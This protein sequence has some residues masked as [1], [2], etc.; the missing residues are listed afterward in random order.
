MTLSETVGKGDFAAAGEERLVSREGWVQIVLLG[1][2][3]F[4]LFY[5]G[6]IRLC[7]Q[8][9]DDPDWQHALI[10]PLISLYFIYQNR[11]RL[12]G[13]ERRHCWV[14]LVMI[15]V[16]I[17]GYTLC[18]YPYRF[19]MGK[20]YM[21]IFALG[22]LVLWMTGK[23]MSKILWFPV[24]YLSFGV[25]VSPKLWGMVSSELQLIASKGASILIDI[26][27]IPLGLETNLSGNQIALYQHAKWIGNLNVAEACSGI[28]SLMMFVALGVAVAFL[29]Q[30]PWWVKVIMVVSTVP[31]AIAANVFRVTAY[32][33]LYPYFPSLT[34]GNPHELLGLVIILAV[35]LSLFL[36]IGWVLE[37]LVITT[38]ES[39]ESEGEQSSGGGG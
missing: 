4:A 27:G 16:G 12:M 19:D 33:L 17:V 21:M 26:L 37:K 3:F 18:I 2:L 39:V 6:L 7:L 30:R 1:G 5:E 23:Q 38:D 25:K 8:A 31:V 14:G 13:M 34:R 28:R 10:M 22:G 20:G 32:G 36:L 29:A 11:E 35:G 9:W 24:V 15:F